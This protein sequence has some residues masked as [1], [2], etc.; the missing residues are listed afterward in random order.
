MRS[1]D[2][3]K[4]W[5]YCTVRLSTEPPLRAL[6]GGEVIEVLTLAATLGLEPQS[7]VRKT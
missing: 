5:G 4:T 2:L 1:Y 7:A 3:F 6:T